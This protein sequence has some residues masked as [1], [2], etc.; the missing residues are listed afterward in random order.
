M[1][2]YYKDS[3]SPRG[4]FIESEKSKEGEVKIKSSRQDLKMIFCRSLSEVKLVFEY[5]VDHNLKYGWLEL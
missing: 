4:L 1:K 3:S 2:G 5:F